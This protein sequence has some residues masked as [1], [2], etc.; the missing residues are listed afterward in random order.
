VTGPSVKVPALALGNVQA[1]V[2]VVP[3]PAN[4]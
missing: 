1:K 2:N 4:A 3:E